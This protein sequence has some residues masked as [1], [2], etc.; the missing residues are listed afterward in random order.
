MDKN[1]GNAAK[2]FKDCVIDARKA[3]ID[4]RNAK[5]NYQKAINSIQ[6][7][8]INY[9][10]LHPDTFFTCGDLAS[11]FDVNP[12]IIYNLLKN[13]P[14][15]HSVHVWIVKRFVEV[16]ENGNQIPNGTIIKTNRKYRA[17]YYK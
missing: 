13:I 3:I 7:N 12:S 4:L 1:R 17:Y 15:V 16:D 5:E 11:T 6:Y 14:T 8:I 2:A 9:L 10:Q